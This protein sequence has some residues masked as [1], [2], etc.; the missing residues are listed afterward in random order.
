VLSDR[1]QADL[2]LEVTQTGSLNLGTGAGNQAAATTH[3]ASHASL[4]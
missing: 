3:L 2:V 1:E 4:K